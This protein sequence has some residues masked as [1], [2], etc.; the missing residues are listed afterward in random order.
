M[1]PGWLVGLRRYLF[2]LRKKKE[3]FNRP[4]P[5]FLLL[6]LERS[7]ARRAV[8]P[9][10]RHTNASTTDTHNP[11]RRLA[12]F[13]F[14]LQDQE[15]YTSPT[16]I[17]DRP[18]PVPRLGILVHGDQRRGV[19]GPVQHGRDAGAVAAVAAA[20]TEAPHGGGLGGRGDEV[21]MAAAWRVRERGEH[22]LLLVVEEGDDAY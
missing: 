12:G 1:F 19:R 22:A 8:N 13:H 16:T 11:L 7:P 5:P 10:I 21:L 17:R 20:R 14:S 18:T 2:Y 9:S 15:S 3:T 4:A 6:W